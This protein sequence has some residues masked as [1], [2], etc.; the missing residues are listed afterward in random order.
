MQAI[1]ALKSLHTGQPQA[2]APISAPTVAAPAPADD[3]TALRL[4][5]LL[6]KYFLLKKVK[7]ATVISYRNTADEL[8]VFLRNPRITRI[9]TSD[10]TRFQEHLAQ[11]GNSVR[12]VAN[13]T[14][15]IRALLNFAK[16]QGYMRQDNPAAGRS[17]VSK[18]QKLKE[19]WATFETDEIVSLVG[20]DFFREKLGTDYATAVLM[21]IFTACRVGEIT[22]LKKDDFKRSRK[23]TPYITIRDSKTVAG[24]REV[25]LHPYIFSH[26]SAKLDTLKN[27]S[28]KL[29]RYKE[30][31]GKGTGNAPGKMLAR[32]LKAAKIDRPKLVFHSLRKYT[33]NELMQGGV[34]L[35]HRCQFAGHEIDNV[36]VAIYTKPFG[37][38]DLAAAIFPTL[39]TI[40]ETVAKAISGAPDFE[41]DFSELIDPM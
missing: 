16:K 5:E 41:V 9:T 28:D 26:I 15:T 1:E 3:P 19:S 27:P 25:P 7:Q 29:F 24:I 31:D 37:I 10:I 6:E 33:N 4:D 8:S 13:K 12:T 30:R 35:E 40:A 36:N 39:T 34:S 11:K 2:P 38:D 14:D 20:C 21:G 22:A 17:L 32:N 23:G 18:K